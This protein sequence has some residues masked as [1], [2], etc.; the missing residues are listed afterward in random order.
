MSRKELDALKERMAKERRQHAAHT[1]PGVKYLNGCVGKLYVKGA[2]WDTLAALRLCADLQV[3]AATAFGLGYYRLHETSV[4]Y[5]AAGFP[6]P[7]A[8]RAAVEQVVERYDDALPLFSAQTDMLYSAEELA[9]EIAAELTSGYRST[10]YQAFRITKRD[11]V[12]RLIEKPALKDLVVQQYLNR[13]LAPILDRMFEPESIGYRKGYSREHAAQRIQ[14]LVR[15]GYRYVVES[16]IDDFFPSVDL[17]RLEA[18]LR[19]QLP[20]ADQPLC[21]LVGAFLRTGYVLDGEEQRRERG[22]AQG[23]P[24]SPL[25][26]NLYLDAFDDT[27]KEHGVR[28]IRYADDFVLL[29]RERAEAERAPGIAEDAAA[30]LGLALDRDKTAIRSVEEGFSFL[31]MAFGREVPAGTELRLAARKPL[32]LIE[33][34]LFLGVNGEAVEL[35][36]AGA[37]IETL[38]LRRLSEIL[39]MERCAVSSALLRKC[40][41]GGVPITFTL[42]SGYHIATL[43]PDSRHHHDLAY[44]QSRRYYAMSETE[45]LTLAS[46]L[47]TVKIQNYLALFRQRY[48]VGTAEFLAGLE[49]LI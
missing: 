30:E 29:A 11:G 7:G 5:F 27:L 26:A 2:G 28:L 18:M 38:P 46:A 45:R 17:D 9:A 8:L 21:Q 6:D 42:G 31:G 47:A 1:E 34:G 20:A 35:R 12:E 49:G 23:A 3:G 39:V 40:V 19:A 22:L 48:E 24:L 16:D 15:E 43:A 25:L 32:Y 13:R 4:P 36:K 33:P 37:L 10:P 41:R 14:A 44:R